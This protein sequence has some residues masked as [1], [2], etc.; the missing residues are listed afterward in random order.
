L[1]QRWLALTACKAQHINGGSTIN[2][3]VMQCA[4]SAQQAQ[5]TVYICAAKHCCCWQQQCLLM[6]YIYMLPRA[7]AVPAAARKGRRLLSW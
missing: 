1:S 4:P 7:V 5:Q 2:M 6:G 3:G